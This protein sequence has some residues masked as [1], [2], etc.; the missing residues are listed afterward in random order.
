MRTASLVLLLVIVSPVYSLEVGYVKVWEKRLSNTIAAVAP[1]AYDSDWVANDI[2]A[3]CYDNRVYFYNEKGELK[4]TYI[5]RSSF[6]A[7]ATYRMPN[8]SHVMRIAAGSLDDYV[9]GLWRAYGTLAIYNDPT[10][11]K[12]PH[13]VNWYFDAG[14]DVSCLGSVDLDEDGVDEAIAVGTRSY[15]SFS[16]GRLIL[17]N[18]TGSKLWER[19]FG[20]EIRYIT[21][22]DPDGDSFLSHLAVAYGNTVVVL[23]K[24]GRTIWTRTFKNEV[25]S[26]APADF[27]GKGELTDLLVA[28]GRRLHAIN[29]RN[30]EL[31]ERAFDYT[32]ASVRSVDSNFD[33]IVDYY[34]ISA[35]PYIIAL[36]NSAYAPNVLWRYYAGE[37][38]GKIV[39]FALEP[40]TPKEDVLAFK[41]NTLTVY[42]KTLIRKPNITL[43]LEKMAEKR[44]KIII[45][46]RGDGDAL[47]ARVMVS[48]QKG[49][50]TVKKLS[51]YLGD[52][53]ESGFS[54]IN[55]SIEEPGNY[56]IKT[57]VY[58]KDEYDVE[59]E[60]RAVF[61]VLLK[62]KD[63]KQKKENKEQNIKK[64]DILL[65]TSSPEEVKEGAKFDVL[66]KLKNRGEGTASNVSLFLVQAKTSLIT[67]VNRTWE[68]ALGA[69]NEKKIS[70]S[71]KVNRKLLWFRSKNLT[72]P[73]VR[74]VYMDQHGNIYSKEAALSPL[75]AKPSKIK[76][77][78]L[79]V[80]F[81]AAVLL[82]YYAYSLRGSGEANIEEEVAK[83]YMKYKAAGKAPPYS[84]FKKLGIDKKTL[85]ELIIKLKKEG[86]IT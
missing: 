77:L 9:Y 65:S 78:L 32:V 62:Q 68:G 60:S 23:D 81:I 51:R 84:A 73:T 63:E 28:E 67:P 82:A 45:K 6:T 80:P 85:K 47:T 18:S 20:R 52:L 74:V 1:F 12:H 75:E 31:W 79:L 37:T 22:F 46:N 57:T 42:T 39:N 71:F 38:V 44:F 14:D 26:I 53:E 11:P 17:L 24:Y 29:S 41:N 70:L 27:W 48:L 19:S 10:E 64:P 69:G 83:I 34:L 40:E 86:K 25:E 58:Y 5:G 33:G 30:L 2:V 35:G 76:Y 4:G 72:L 50:E 21:S 59:Y 15:Y 54:E 66:V 8:R 3:A 55:L 7:L 61:Y 16:P 36:K 56:S 43:S 13:N 49:N